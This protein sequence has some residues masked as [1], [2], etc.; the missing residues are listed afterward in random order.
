MEKCLDCNSILK[1]GETFCYLCGAKVERKDAGG[2]VGGILLKTINFLLISSAL[3]SAGH[4]FFEFSPP[5]S[6]CM[7]ATLVLG[8]VKSSAGQMA[9]QKRE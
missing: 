6:K 7:V 3:L 4:L 5:F 8:V 2:G 9:E 1:R